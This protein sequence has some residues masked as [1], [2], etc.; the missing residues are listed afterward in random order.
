M[1]KQPRSDRKETIANAERCAAFL[2]WFSLGLGTVQMVAPRRLARW[3][4]I[5]EKAENCALI[6]A[7]GLR[8]ILSGVGILTSPRPTGWLWGRVGGDAMDL[9]LLGGA[10]QADTTEKSRVTAATAAVVGVTV[11]DVWCSQYFSRTPAASLHAGGKETRTDLKEAV[12]INRSPEELYRFW[13]NCLHGGGK[14]QHGLSQW[15]NRFGG[16]PM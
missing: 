1:P 11:L 15:R 3:I 5:E 13:H 4:G 14:L 7:L 8:E 12:T 10:L 9:S 6:R 2:G 16:M